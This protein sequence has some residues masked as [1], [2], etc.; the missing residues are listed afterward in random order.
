MFRC[1]FV[2]A[3]LVCLTLHSIAAAPTW[4]SAHGLIFS[5]QADDYSPINQGQLKRFAAEGCS[6]LNAQLPGGAGTAL[7]D[8]IAA[9]HSPSPETDDYAVANIGQV[10]AIARL[11]YLRFAEFNFHEPPVP[12][13]G[14]G[15][16]FPW[17]DDPAATDDF[18]YA[19]IGQ[20]KYLFS[21]DL[22]KDTD[23]DGIPD[24]WEDYYGL[25]KN[26]PSDALLDSDGDGITNL[27]EYRGR[28]NPR[29]WYNGAPAVLAVQAG[30]G[31]AVAPTIT[32]T[33]SLSV[34][35]TN[36]LTGLPSVNAP[37]NFS[38]ASGGG[39]LSAATVSTGNDGVA[40]VSFTAPAFDATCVV[41]ASAASSAQ[42]AN[43]AF[44]VQ[45]LSPAAPSNLRAEA[46][47]YQ[48]TTT[49]SWNDNSQTETGFIV[50]KQ[51]PDGTWSFVGSV[52]PNTTRFVY[53][54]GGGAT[55]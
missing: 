50:E 33:D 40:Q 44:E 43:V 18:A 31:Q 14:S 53:F 25:N 36:P 15:H 5:D 8:L 11:F 55:N 19:N 49:L 42:A 12:A 6:E 41:T 30:A 47:I 48:Q 23:G 32:A 38:I 22:R 52:P 4:W 1:V 21:F 34:L 27:D 29:D 26:D 13:A 2:A 51:N 3:T 45:S 10:K 46:G 17:T 7:N 9:W 24:L 39:S 16:I 54:F 37:V 28:T 20:V 35:V